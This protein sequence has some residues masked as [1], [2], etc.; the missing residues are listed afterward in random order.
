MTPREQS[1]LAQLLRCA[2]DTESLAKDP[3]AEALVGAAVAVHPSLPYWL[4]YRVVLLTRALESAES[5]IE[6]LRKALRER[7]ARSPRL[8]RS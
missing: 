7:A 4:A 5:E 2:A 6:F 1:L 3:E 8:S